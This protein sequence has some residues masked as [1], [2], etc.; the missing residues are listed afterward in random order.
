M[1]WLAVLSLFAL[2]GAHG[3]VVRVERVQASVVE[4]PGGKFVM[5]PSQDDVD[6]AYSSCITLHGQNRSQ[7]PW[8]GTSAFCDEYREMLEA[9]L[10]RD[11]VV[12]GFAIDRDEVTS[13]A[14]RACIRAG[15]CELDPLIDNDE[16][17][18]GDGLPLVNVTWSEA[19]T[20]CAWRGGRLPTEAEWE[21]AA[22]GDDA[23]RWPWGD[24]DE[25]EDWNHG[26][27]PS[28]AMN[29]VDDM[30]S[31][32]G[33]MYGSGSTLTF[34]FFGDPDDSDGFRYAAPAGSFPWDEGPYGTRDQAGNVAEW[35]ADELTDDGY[36]DLPV[37]NPVRN[38]D[39]SGSLKRAIRGGSWQDPLGYG[40][41]FLR[42]AVNLLMAGDERYATVGFRCAY[43]R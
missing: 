30:P 14:Y 21:R 10:E 29:A 9:M 4:V 1:R 37:A 27:L 32:N 34:T 40:Q 13:D 8:N 20:F 26:Q 3:R 39:G 38:P 36:T 22:R 41:T 17:Y 24:K 31:R 6:A 15:A 25:P 43:D 18:N 2:M 16:R 19:R 42:S 5:G 23:R 11:V 28:D 12:S 35:T 33:K 7:I